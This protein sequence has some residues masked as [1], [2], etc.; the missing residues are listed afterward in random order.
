MNTLSED[1][2]R[3]DEPVRLLL[4]NLTSDLFF[5]NLMRILLLISYFHQTTVA[6]NLTN[7][8]DSVILQYVIDDYYGNEIQTFSNLYVS[9]LTDQFIKIHLTILTT[10]LHIVNL[11]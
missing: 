8:V 9:K 7:I 4:G 10:L 5:Q 1:S 3:T 2:L 11:N 6:G